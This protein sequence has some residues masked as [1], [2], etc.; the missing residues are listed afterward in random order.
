LRAQ[1]EHRREQ[2]AGRRGG[3]GNRA[4]AEPYEEDKRD[5]AEM[6]IGNDH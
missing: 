6:R 5:E 4:K 1:H 2:P 3:V